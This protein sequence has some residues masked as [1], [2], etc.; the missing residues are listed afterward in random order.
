[1]MEKSIIRMHYLRKVFFLI[2]FIDCSVPSPCSKLLQR[3][4]PKVLNAYTGLR[5]IKK[6]QQHG[7]TEMEFVYKP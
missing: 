5:Y 2:S 3:W 4:K 1:M 6:S 7:V